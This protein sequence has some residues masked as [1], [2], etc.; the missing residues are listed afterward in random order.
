MPFDFN[1]TN[2][3]QT[4]LVPPRP[5]SPPPPPSSNR[6]ES[7][8]GFQNRP[9]R[10]E[11]SGGSMK[12]APRE[13]NRPANSRG[14]SRPPVRRAPSAY[15]SFSIPW[16]IVFWVL[17]I[18]AVVVGLWVFRDAISAF[19]SQVLSWVIMILVILGIIRLFLFPRR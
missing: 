11:S 19:L 18:L 17:G 9:Q 2:R 3:S 6:T 7:A 13:P 15:S 1:N 5:T 14:I 12:P 10:R 4:P 8:G 16:N